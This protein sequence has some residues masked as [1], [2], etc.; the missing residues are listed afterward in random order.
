MTKLTAE[1]HKALLEYAAEHGRN[2]KSELNHDW[3]TG[4]SEGYLR[5]IRNQF[6]PS[7]LM[8]FKL[9]PAEGEL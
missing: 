5:Q 6:G 7:W 1:Q 4:Q 8:R 3:L 9:P 2:W